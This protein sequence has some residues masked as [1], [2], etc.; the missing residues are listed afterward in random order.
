MDDMDFISSRL[1]EWRYTGSIGNWF[2]E[3]CTLTYT[4]ASESFG[5]Q[6]FNIYPNPNN[7]NFTVNFDSNTGNDAKSWRT[8]YERTIGF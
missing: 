2:V 5:L 6:N 8:R 3:V 7:G 1:L 4:L